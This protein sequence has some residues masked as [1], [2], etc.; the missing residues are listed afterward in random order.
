M[1]E[2]VAS[3]RFSAAAMAGFMR[4][5]LLGAGTPADSNLRSS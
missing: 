3:T 1:Q 4:A 5:T 2:N